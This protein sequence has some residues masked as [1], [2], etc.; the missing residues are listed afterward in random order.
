[1]VQIFAAAAFASKA[2]LC[3]ICVGRFGWG[4]GANRGASVKLP[5]ASPMSSR[6]N[7]SQLQDGAAA[8]QG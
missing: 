4:L 3:R 6:A 7:A 8:G 2:L 1:M 5:E